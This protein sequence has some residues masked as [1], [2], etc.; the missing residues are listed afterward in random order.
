MSKTLT[1]RFRT[2]REAELAIEHLV[3]QES[4]DRRS[5][6]VLPVG[7]HNSAG[8]Q[9]AG[10]DQ[11]DAHQGSRERGDAALMGPVEISVLLPEGRAEA[12]RQVLESAGARDLDAI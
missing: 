6:S 12:I 5:I 7:N 3:Q 8:T 11:P 1:G 10:S 2:R 4:L 9:V